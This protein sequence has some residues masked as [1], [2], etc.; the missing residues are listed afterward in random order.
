MDN[1]RRKARRDREVPQADGQRQGNHDQALQGIQSKTDK[2]TKQVE[3]EPPPGHQLES[4]KLY[5]ERARARLANAVGEVAEFMETLVTKQEAVAELQGQVKEADAG[6]AQVRAD[7]AKGAENP[8]PAAAT[9]PE[10]ETILKGVYGIAIK[11]DKETEQAVITQTTAA[12]GREPHGP[13][14]KEEVG[15][16]EGDAPPSRRQ[17]AGRRADGQGPLTNK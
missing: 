8:T 12:E 5:L 11:E 6:L 2:L 13:D 15:K 4:T 1:Q 17:T 14:A 16:D 10:L 7:L 3:K 9:V